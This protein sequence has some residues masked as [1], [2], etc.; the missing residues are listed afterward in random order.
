MA[1]YGVLIGLTGLAG[2]LYFEMRPVRIVAPS[3]SI[4]LAGSES[5]R[6][7]VTACAESFMARNPKTDVI[8]R[9][10]G[11][12]DGVAA[13][14]HGLVDVGM[15]SRDLSKPERDYASSKGM[16][17]SQA[18]LALDGI[19]IIVNRTNPIVELSLAQIQSIF[20]G[21]VRNWRELQGEDREIQAFGRATGS[22]TAMLFTERVLGETPSAALVEKLPTNEAIVAQV[23]ARPGSIGYTGIGALSGSRD[24]IK[25]VSIRA[26]QQSPPTAATAEEI[27]SGRYP[28]ARTLAFATPSPVSGTSKAFI[29]F[30]L[31]PSGQALVQRAGYVA[32]NAS[33][34]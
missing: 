13:L 25:A 32:I 10:G 24:R 31:G 16:E 20:A 33:G 29:D 22:G 5:M 2:F 27:R 1:V 4:Q 21:K 14:L 17:I 7:V 15:I 8:V 34:G 11:S 6:P 28:L 18:P 3:G 9:G 30:C 19:A 23:A 12:G 26:D